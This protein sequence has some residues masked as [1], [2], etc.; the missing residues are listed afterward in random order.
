MHD[1]GQIYLIIVSWGIPFLIAHG[2]KC[3]Q[4]PYLR[5]SVVGLVEAKWRVR[6][7]AKMEK[8]VMTLGQEIHTEPFADQQ[9][10]DCFVR[11][12]R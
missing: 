2:C 11:V 12:R 3:R 10:C 6:G 9:D 4:P 7:C 8:I 1:N 5:R